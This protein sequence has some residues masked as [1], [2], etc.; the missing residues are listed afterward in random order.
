[1]NSFAASGLVALPEITRNCSPRTP[2]QGAP[3][4]A[5]SPRKMLSKESNEPEKFGPNLKKWLQVGASPRGTLALDRAS[6]AH[7]WLRGRDHA[8]PDDVRAVAADCLRHRLILSYEAAADDVF[9][10]A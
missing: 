7:A 5:G 2:P 9:D 10:P 4:P 6:R 1:M 8:T 3:P